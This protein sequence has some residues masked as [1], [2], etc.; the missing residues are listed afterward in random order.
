MK[1]KII[2]G[3]FAAL[4][5][6][7][8]VARAQDS[9]ST[10]TTT[11]TTTK[12]EDNKD[13]KDKEEFHHGEFGLQFIPMVTRMDFN[14]SNGDVVTADAVLGMG[15]GGKIGLNF[16][17]CFGLLGEVNY[18][19]IMQR[20]KD[21][22]LERE[23]HLN[24]LD[25]PVLLVL[26]TDKTK[27]VMFNVH[28]GPQFGINVGSSVSGGQTSETDTVHAV[29]AVKQGDVGLAYGAGLG[30]M[31]IPDKN[32]L[33]LDLGFRGMYGLIDTRGDQTSADTY[34]VLVKA[35]RK[36]YGGYLGLTLLF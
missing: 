28:A 7:G 8:I 18:D 2:M 26:S 1:K 35:S 33:R 22:D 5:S 23:V 32:T 17:P 31:L 21:K 27:P 16:S 15:Y 4:F 36:A 25:I 13:N 12:V 10:T 9:T 19:A 3:A 30:F 34:N 24:Y 29:I 20:Y 6:M 11:T 14:T